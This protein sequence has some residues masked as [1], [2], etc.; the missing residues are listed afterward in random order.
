MQRR[1][2]KQRGRVASAA[3]LQAAWRNIQVRCHSAVF[4]PLDRACCTLH[5]ACSRPDRCTRCGAGAS[6]TLR[7]RRRVLSGCRAASASCRC[8]VA[9]LRRSQ[10]ANRYPSIHPSTAPWALTPQQRPNLRWLRRLL[11]CAG[12][13]WRARRHARAVSAEQP[14][15]VARVRAPTEGSSVNSPPSRLG[16]APVWLGMVPV[17]LLCGSD[18]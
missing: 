5:D 7:Q 18:C 1:V 11:F 16:A 9:S 2:E 13:S 8:A 3:H 12:R 17:W 4:S 14:A 6:C 10:A 15:A